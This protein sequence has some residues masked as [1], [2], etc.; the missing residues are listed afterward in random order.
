VCYAYRFAR[1][2]FVWAGEAPFC[3]PALRLFSIEQVLP[4]PVDMEHQA[5]APVSPHY[6]PAH[7]SSIGNP[8]ADL[9]SI[10]KSGVRTI[11]IA[12]HPQTHSTQRNW[13]SDTPSVTDGYWPFVRTGETPPIQ[14]TLQRVWFYFSHLFWIRH[15]EHCDDARR[16]IQ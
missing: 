10:S 14:N 16:R 5:Q 6:T 7:G 9:E 15:W 12:W 8:N 1:S 13:N 11:R 3:T 4:V 2:D